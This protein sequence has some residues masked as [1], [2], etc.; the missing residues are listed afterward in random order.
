[1]LYLEDYVERKALSIYYFYHFFSAYLDQFK[2]FSWVCKP[3]VHRSVVV[4]LQLRIEVRPVY[5]DRFD[6]MFPSEL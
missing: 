2:L 1:M 3:S 6:V 4:T 5:T